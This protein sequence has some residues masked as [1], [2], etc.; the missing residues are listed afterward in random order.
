MR[1]PMPRGKRGGLGCGGILLL[2]VLS[3]VFKQDFLSL[4]GAGVGGGGMATT[5]D[6]FGG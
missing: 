5:T 1:L 4:V 6:T 3:V 2:L